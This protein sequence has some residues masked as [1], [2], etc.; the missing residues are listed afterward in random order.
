MD[1]TRL[2]E[3]ILFGKFG[4]TLMR[5]SSVLSRR[6]IQA[7]VAVAFFAGSAVAQGQVTW[8]EGR[9]E[10]L[11]SVGE[12]EEA[13]FEYLLGLPVSVCEG[14]DGSLYVADR[15]SMDIRQ[16]DRDGRYV[17][18]IGSRG[19]GPGEFTRLLNIYT[20]DDRTSL[21]VLD[22]ENRR[23]S[24]F[25][26]ESGE[27][28]STAT[29]SSYGRPAMDILPDGR[30]VMTF[31][32]GAAPGGLAEMPSITTI[33]VS[34]T[35]A[36]TEKFVIPEDVWSG[37][38]VVRTDLSAFPGSILARANGTVLYAPHLY[39][40]RIFSMRTKGAMAL[41]EVIEGGFTGRPLYEKASAPSDNKYPDFAYTPE[42]KSE[43]LYFRF[44]CQSMALFE[45]GSGVGHM[46][47]CEIDGKRRHAVE[48]FDAD[49]EFVGALTLAEWDPDIDAS[50]GVRIGDVNRNLEFYAWR[51]GGKDRPPV[52]FVARLVL[53][54]RLRTLLGIKD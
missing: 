20:S 6:L 53:D 41:S 23:I 1:V 35:D 25:D 42:G 45:A 19:R 5:F 49:A 38:F 4:E 17:R 26:T 51:S 50:T 40:G 39:D 14:P 43:M 22:G 12:N 29:F 21:F 36:P 27:L 47:F 8:F 52:A 28:R 15:T 18:T 13:E 54:E 34:T 30:H 2:R 37:D 3:T 9:I 32:A 44:P 31:V 16:F 33:D 10:M 46:I 24:R 48:F 11:R 7:L